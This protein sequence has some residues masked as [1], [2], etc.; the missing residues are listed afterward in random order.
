MEAE[1]REQAK[2]NK[3]E[4]HRRAKAERKEEPEVGKLV[5]KV[6]PASQIAESSQNSLFPI[7]GE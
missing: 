4:T 3:E 5:L 7:Q 2:W 6:G 1:R